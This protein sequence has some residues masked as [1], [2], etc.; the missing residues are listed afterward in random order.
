MARRGRGG[1]ARGRTTSRGSDTP[2]RGRSSHARGRNGCGDGTR[3]GSCQARGRTPGRGRD[4]LEAGRK[5]AAE[6]ERAVEEAAKLEAACQA[7]AEAA[8]LEAARKTADSARQAA[9]EAAKIEATQWKAAAAGCQAAEDAAKLEANRRA[10][11]ER[12][13]LEVSQPAVTATDEAATS[14]ISTCA[15]AQSIPYSDTL[16][17]DGDEW[18]IGRDPGPF[19]APFGMQ[20]KEACELAKEVLRLLADGQPRNLGSLRN[21]DNIG[22]RFNKLFF[23]KRSVNNGSWKKWLATLPNADT[24][25]LDGQADRVRLRPQP[26]DCDS[27]AR[28]APD[29]GPLEAAAATAKEPSEAV[30]ELGSNAAPEAEAAAKAAEAVPSPPYSEARSEEAKWI[31]GAS[32]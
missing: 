14:D 6:V 16:V 13:Q 12:A 8:R 3:G 29:R 32:L 19:S 31:V 30:T 23:Q 4:K 10:A 26:S 24:W 11:E 15:K 25:N 5:A 28:A 17:A 1:Q 2:S 20:T 21:I 18:I 7:S 27:G 9:E 22:I